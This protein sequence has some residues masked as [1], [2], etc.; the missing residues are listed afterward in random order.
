MISVATFLSHFPSFS[1]IPETEIQ[2]WLD[3]A[4]DF[5]NKSNW[6]IY[7][8]R[9]VELW[10]AHNIAL[11]QMQSAGDGMGSL[12]N[13]QGVPASKSVDNVSKS[14]DTSMFNVGND[15]SKDGDYLFTIYG[16][17]YLT[18]RNAVISPVALL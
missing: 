18:L 12:A 6:G 13:L 17:R 15:A 5:L 1:N 3:L 16:R 4:Q 8:E 11:D 7:W 10:T 9:A 14:Y 2:H